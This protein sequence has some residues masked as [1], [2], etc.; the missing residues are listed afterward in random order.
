MM[1]RILVC[2]MAAILL[3]LLGGCRRRIMPE[4]EQV[5][6]E[7]YLQQTTEPSQEPD[8]PSTE[9]TQAPSTEEQEPTTR[10]RRLPQPSLPRAAIRGLLSRHSQ[11]SPPSPRRSQS[12]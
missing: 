7:T 10:I 2:F 4:A 11:H 12:R 5:V 6:Y 9:E 8:E 3:L 1:K